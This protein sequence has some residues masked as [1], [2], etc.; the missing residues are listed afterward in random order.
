[1][2]EFRY[3]RDEPPSDTTRRLEKANDRYYA[4]RVF[5]VFAVRL[6]DRRTLSKS[7]KLRGGKQLVGFIRQPRL[8]DVPAKADSD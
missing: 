6:A 2:R 7:R 1:M 5:K 3:E 4:V 8:L